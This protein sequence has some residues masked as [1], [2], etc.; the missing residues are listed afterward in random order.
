M[1]Q[2]KGCYPGHN[3]M[4]TSHTSVFEMFRWETDLETI[5]Y[6]ATS[7]FLPALPAKVLAAHDDH[8]RTFPEL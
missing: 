1:T 2:K 8:T 3:N 6:V 7:V 5:S 4:E